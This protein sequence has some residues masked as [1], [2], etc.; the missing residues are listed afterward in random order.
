MA[1]PASI[2]PSLSAA[3]AGPFTSLVLTVDP[4]TVWTD[5]LLEREGDTM[6]EAKGKFT[7]VLP[8]EASRE[9]CGRSM[10]VSIRDFSRLSSDPRRGCGS[11][12]GRPFIAPH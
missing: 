8:Q 5:V 9:L 1:N 10:P 3:P 6:I 12:E 11:R 2:T 4:K 7:S